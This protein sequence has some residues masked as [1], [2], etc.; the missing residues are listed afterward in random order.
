M[1]QQAYGFTSNYTDPQSGLNLPQAWIQI[2]TIQYRP[3]DHVLI[4]VDIYEDLASKQSGM[5]PVF[6]N[7]Q[8]KIGYGSLDW[9]TYFD[10]DSMDVAGHNIQKEAIDW[11]SININNIKRSI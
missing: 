8:M 4:A 10:P 11:L 5:A 7:I 9:D 1:T 2:S 3:Y 6:Q